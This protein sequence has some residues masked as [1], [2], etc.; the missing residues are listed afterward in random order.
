[1]SPSQKVVTR[2][3]TGRGRGIER[4]G[5][6]PPD[7]PVERA[8]EKDVNV[9]AREAAL[10]P[11]SSP[12]TRIRAL[13]RR[14]TVGARP[15]CRL[16]IPAR[17]TTCSLRVVTPGRVGD[18]ARSSAPARNGANRNEEE[19]VEDGVDLVE[20]ALWHAPV[21]T[22]TDVCLGREH[23]GPPPAN[24]GGIHHARLL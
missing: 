9:T 8:T 18:A 16:V 11:S 5:R 17:S 21:R 14:G 23:E 1:M 10:L 20:D 3:P 15:C 24:L 22:S 13:A 4:A 7:P 2:R 19:P 6:K 12:T